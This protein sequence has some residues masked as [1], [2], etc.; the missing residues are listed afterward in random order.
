MSGHCSRSDAAEPP[1]VVGLLTEALNHRLPLSPGKHRRPRLFLAHMVIFAF[2]NTGSGKT[3]AVLGSP[4]QKGLLQRVVDQVYRSK[5]GSRICMT[6]REYHLN[7][8]KVN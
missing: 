1:D 2:G 7:K 3:H 8:A 6:A 4:G 5:V